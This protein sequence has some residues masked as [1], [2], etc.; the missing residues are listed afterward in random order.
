MQRTGFR[1]EAQ[2]LAAELAGRGAGGRPLAIVLGSGL[3]GLVERLRATRVIA[4]DE[5]EHLPRSRVKGHAGE[6][7]LGELAGLPVIVQSGR[8]HLYEGVAPLVVTR[9]VRAYA[10]LGVRAVLLTNASGGLVPEWTPGTFLRLTDHLNLQGCTPLLPG[11][12]ARTSPYDEALGA[13]L[14]SAARALRI[15]LRNGVYAGL[16]GPSYETPAEIRAL[17]ALG[18]HAVGMSTVAE[19]CAARAAGMRVV[20]LSCIANPAAGLAA[21]ALRH[22]DVLSVMRRSTEKL[23]RLLEHVAPLWLRAL[24]S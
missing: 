17:R 13:D 7:V 3:G 11:E 1:I 10:E 18:A 12:E 21:E 16:L 23:A 20:A 6:I 5:L 19:A 4:G 2:R 14:E 24:G 22:D 15:E 9:A 8:V